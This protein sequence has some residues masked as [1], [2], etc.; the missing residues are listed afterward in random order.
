MVL[1]GREVMRDW[2]DW[3]RSPDHYAGTALSSVFV[4]LTHRLRPEPELAA[5]RRRPA[6]RH[7]G[8]AGAGHRQPRPGARPPGAAAPGARADRRGCGLRPVGGRR[9]RRRGVG[10]AGARG[11]R[12]RGR[13]LRAV[14]R[15]TSSPSSTRRSGDW[16]IGEERYDALL[17]EAE[18]LAYGTRAL[19]DKGQAAYDELAADMRGQGAGAAR[20]RRLHRRGQGLQRRPP[21]DAGGDARALPRGD[22]RGARR[23]ASSTSWSP[24]PTGEQCEVVPSAPFSRAMLAVAHYMAPPPF[25]PAGDDL[26]CRALL[27]ALPAGRR[28]ARSRSTR[29]WPPTTTTAPGRSRCTRPT[30]ATT[31]TSPGCR[32][33]PAGGGSRPLRFV[34]RLDLLRRGLGPLHRGPAARAGLLPRRRS[35]SSA[36]ATT[37]CSAPPGSSSTPRCTSAR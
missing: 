3:R 14:R 2:A 9:V 28:H 36:S 30:R 10:R 8:A 22:R 33:G 13:G 6:A 34:L 5:G 27:R 25:A 23:S 7:P 24:C 11:G 29:G 12:G 32:P 1:R 21:G 17:T 19:R 31:G 20:H 15:R 37:G 16:A 4:L 26:R 18:G 35:R